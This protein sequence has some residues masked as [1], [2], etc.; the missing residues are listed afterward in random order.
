MTSKKVTSFEQLAMRAVK[1]QI[2]YSLDSIRGF[3][4]SLRFFKT[5]F[6]AKGDYG[7]TNTVWL[8]LEAVHPK[9]WDL[10][11]IVVTY[12]GHQLYLEDIC[13]RAEEYFGLSVRR[14]RKRLISQIL[15]G[16]TVDI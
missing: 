15:E 14:F 16:G 6:K 4:F 11:P 9:Y 7:Y 13:Q 5:T 2:K 3:S 12:K 1:R 10:I 8:E